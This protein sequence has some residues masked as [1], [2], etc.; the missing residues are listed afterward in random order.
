MKEVDAAKTERQ[1]H[2]IEA[3]L[4]DRGPVYADIW[5]IGVNTALRISDLLTLTMADVKSL[6]PKQP[7]LKLKEKKDRKIPKNRHQPIRS[8]GDA[9][10][11]ER[12]PQAQMVIPIRGTESRQTS[13]C[14]SDQPPIRV[15][16]VSAGRS[17]RCAQSCVGYALHA[18]DTWLRHAQGG[19][20]H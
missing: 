9:T 1:R 17:E 20:I 7:A 2:Q 14:S 13:P 12:K 8:D 5:K 16:G 19:A 10:P 3:H 11:I 18:Q 4:L 15:T 6:D